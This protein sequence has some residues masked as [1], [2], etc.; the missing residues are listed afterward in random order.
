MVADYAHS[1]YARPSH[2]AE[3]TQ[4]SRSVVND[5]VPSPA[6]P[7][8]LEGGERRKLPDV[9]KTAEVARLMGFSGRT[10][11][12]MANAGTLRGFRHVSPRGI[13]RGNDWRF[14]AED[15]AKAFNL[16][17]QELQRLWSSRAWRPEPRT[18]A[19]D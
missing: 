12:G 9:L 1:L 10:I 19:G 8:P 13:A 6:S 5:D 2:F 3:G 16:P 14:F 4:I 17:L 11:S 15:V 18:K 7:D